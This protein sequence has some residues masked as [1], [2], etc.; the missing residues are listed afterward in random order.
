VI[1]SYVDYVFPNSKLALEGRPPAVAPYT[2]SIVDGQGVV[3]DDGLFVAPKS[4]GATTVELTDDEGTTFQ[5]TIQCFDIDKMILQIVQSDLGLESDQ[6]FIFNQKIKIP[7]D[8]R[9]YVTL[10][11]VTQKSYG[12]NVLTRDRGKRSLSVSALYDINFFSPSLMT[13]LV[14]DKAMAV[15]NSVL[16]EKLQSFN[17]FSI[18]R[19][20]ES[21][22]D[23]SFIEKTSPINRFVL[24]IRVN[25]NKIIDTNNYTFFNENIEGELYG[26]KSQ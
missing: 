21:L 23:I 3:G 5:K 22:K 14:K 24:S 13:R 11:F 12:T 2:W 16:S 9:L 7:N 1:D 17:A 20:I 26:L 4:E 10:N 8:Q 15:F 18:Q 19:N 25:Y 6:I